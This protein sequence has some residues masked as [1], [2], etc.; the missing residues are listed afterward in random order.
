MAQSNH[1][2]VGKALDLLRKGLYPYVEREMKAAYGK[3]WPLDARDALRDDWNNGVNWDSQA[4]LKLMWFRWN[5][6]FTRQLGPSERGLVGELR[7]IR[8][9]WAHQKSFT[10]DDTYRA[11][12]TLQRLLTAVAAP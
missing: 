12:D 8:N 3:D 10:A 9:N 7:G 6:V 2:R 5:E 1:E 4:L 11:L